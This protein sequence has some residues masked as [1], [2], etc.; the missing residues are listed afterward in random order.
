MLQ[1]KRM[2]YRKHFRGSMNG[3]ANVGSKVSFGEYGLK[4]MD[5]GWM[6]NRQI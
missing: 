3:N 1:P 6:T 5:R 2:K 4:A